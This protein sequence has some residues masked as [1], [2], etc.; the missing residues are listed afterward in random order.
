MAARLGGTASAVLPSGLPDP[1]V[2]SESP[3]FRRP[4]DVSISARRWARQ[5]RRALAKQVRSRL[6]EM[7][8][9]VLTVDEERVLECAGLDALVMLRFCALCGRFCALAGAFGLLLTPLYSAG[10]GSPLLDVFGIGAALA[11]STSSLPGVQHSLSRF[12][13]ANLGPGSLSLWAV[14]PVAYGCTLVLC[15]LLWKEYERFVVLRRC[16]LGGEALSLRTSPGGASVPQD[17]AAILAADFPWQRGLTP[18]PL[19]QAGGEGLETPRPGERG[20]AEFPACLEQMRRTVLVERLPQDLREPSALRACF[21][22]LLGERTV[23]S[24]AMV[25]PD[26]RKLSE[27]LRE[28]ARLLREGGDLGALAALDERL[29]SR[30]E[31]FGRAMATGPRFLFH[32]KTT[33]QSS[34]GLLDCPSARDLSEWY[35]QQ[36]NA[37]AGSLV[38]LPPG[39]PEESE[40]PQ[41]GFTLREIWGRQGPG[42]RGPIFRGR[43]PSPEPEGAEPAEAA[44]G[45]CGGGAAAGALSPRHLRED[46][47]TRGPHL[48]GNSWASSNSD[49]AFSRG[50][51]S[52][53]SVSSFRE[54]CLAASLFMRTAGRS[55]LYTMR[56]MVQCARD[57]LGTTMQRMGQLFPAS[58]LGTPAPSSALGTP[59][60]SERSNW[61][62]K[63]DKHGPNSVCHS[64]TA[65]VTFRTLQ[66]AC[67]ACQVV[68]DE[69]PVLGSELVASQAPEPRDIVWH[70]AAR[71]Q[72]QRLVRQFFVEVAM[73][74]G[75]AF[76]SV[77][78]SLLQAWCS[79]ARLQNLLG[80]SFQLPENFVKSDIYSLITLYLPVMA[81]LGLLE[82]LPVLL[83]RLSSRY[84]GIK[85]RSSL[86]M[87][88]MQRYWRFQLA[89]IAVTALSGSLSDSWTAI[90]TDPSAVLWHLGQSLPK[91]AVYFLVT[92]LSSA[93]VVAPVSLLRLP[94]LARIAA[95]A[96]HQRA[97]CL[98]RCHPRHWSPPGSAEGGP[99]AAEV[100]LQSPDHAADLSALLL[101]L[102]VCVTYATVAPFILPA[103]LLFFVVKWLVLAVQYL[104]VHVPRFDSGGAFWH[105]LWNQALLALVLGNLTTLALVGLRSGYAQLPFLLPLPVLPIGFKLR[106]EYRFAEPSRRLSLRLARA[107]DARD[108]RTADR[109]SPD[110]YWHPA[111][112]LAEGEMLA[113]GRRNDW[114]R[115]SGPHLDSLMERSETEHVVAEPVSHVPS[116]I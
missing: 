102:L 41:V 19:T 60:T 93:L 115:G 77:P 114:D 43:P 92:V 70:N 68:L 69:D 105:L 3:S 16:Y 2:A 46:V 48:R 17:C 26:A 59:F 22:E 6:V 8:R 42:I 12:T 25:P 83:Y 5:I 38:S 35:D 23:H 66:A 97:C 89:T 62:S 111:L 79:V 50:P 10:G 71:P 88:T 30:R 96:V 72:A 33:S 101:V 24:V 82:V 47:R 7:L 45:P 73:F 13:L 80:P 27:M 56:A 36:T 49:E 9:A 20:S 104:Y 87:V 18:P 4:S 39:G 63:A 109:F 34:G 37:T 32:P 91:V 107:L 40:D 67:I 90:R 100:F 108:A 58:A 106:A 85:S 75:L 52:S 103:G 1:T 81:L 54:L 74:V 76:W 113:G 116:Q 51:N 99:V 94:V 112:R 61:P 78:V 64:T 84:E 57:V 14:V 55:V 31:E 11:N 53:S 95:T 110:A 65:F 44:C 29:C 98:R 21:E 15:G 86:Q 28:R